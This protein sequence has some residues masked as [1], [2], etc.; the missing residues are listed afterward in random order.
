[1]EVRLGEYGP[2]SFEIAGVILSRRQLG[3]N[4][5]ETRPTEDLRFVVFWDGD[6]FDDAFGLLKETVGDAGA[7]EEVECASAYD[8]LL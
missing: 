7:V 5:G 6:N 4:Y 8:A 3:W 1:M 2:D